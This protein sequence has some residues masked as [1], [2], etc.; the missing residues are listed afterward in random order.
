MQKRNKDSLVLYY[1]YINLLLNAPSMIEAFNRN[2]LK[3]TNIG[4]L[5]LNR[6]TIRLIELCPACCIAGV[7]YN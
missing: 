7:T 2:T 6:S 3:F 1:R 4:I 5:L